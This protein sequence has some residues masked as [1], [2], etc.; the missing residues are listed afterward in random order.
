MFQISNDKQRVLDE[1]GHMLIMGGPGSGKTTIAL[2]K[3][4]SI[5]ESGILQNE[6]TV[7]FLSFARSTI[8]RVEQ[9]SQAVIEKNVRKRIEITTYHSFIWSILRSHGYLLN[10]KKIGILLPHEASVVLSKCKNAQER[11]CEKQRLFDEE[12]RIHFDL[13]A[14]KCYEVLSQSNRLLQ[15]I[16]SAYPFIIL[17]EFQDTNTDEWN[18]IKVLGKN[19]TLIAL[20]D[21]EQRI[22]D[23]RGADP[24][25]I[26]QYIDFLSPKEFDFGMEN[27]RS[28]G[29]DIVEFGNDL[30][31]GRNLGKQYDDV[32]I[33]KYDVRKRNAHLLDIKWF[34]LKR[35][36]ALSQE[37]T[38]NWS[39][40]ILVPTN[41]L[42]ITI[43]DMLGKSQKLSSGKIAPPV[44]HEVAIEAAGPALAATFI[45][46]LL[47]FG[48]QEKSCFSNVVVKL[49]EHIL[50][51]KG[52]KPPSQ[53]DNALAAALRNYIDAQNYDKP[54]RGSARQR[55]IN[56]C[57]KI[58]DAANALIFTGE[59][60]QDWISVRN[61]L[62]ETSLPNI[63]Q[64][65]LDSF[66][67][68]LLHKGTLLN[69]SLG[70]LWRQNGNYSG[71]V[72]AVK[73]ALT[74]EHFA[75]SAKVWRGVNIMTIH[76]SKG[77]EFDEVLVFEGAFQGQR[78]VYS[79][80]D[81]DKA[82]INLRVAATRAKQKAYFVTPSTDPCSLLISTD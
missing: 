18:L 48:S 49:G 11:E 20:A 3:A 9:H 58:S 75:S 63:K 29:T 27:N 66:F 46:H 51:R 67:V 57:R 10:T 39:I 15:I 71:A 82:R 19:S 73:E 25:R 1:T 37:L 65:Y 23:F 80:T 70:Q 81:L 7:L 16:S 4:K 30:L 36:K 68:K 8:A 76:K 45:A 74:Q 52:D 54:I 13:F 31:V 62:S 32:I 2:L 56:E 60:A 12:G 34:L 64:V 17:D 61:L 22:Y 79:D 38:D 24:A 50:G 78:F 43:S 33:Y 72:D 53:G 26:K 35:I 44:E 6:Q 42:M 28:N 77:K 5:V 69:S 47:E 40:A 59:V 14:R 41:T 21:P 55:V